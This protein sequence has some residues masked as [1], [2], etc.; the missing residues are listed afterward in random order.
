MAFWWKAQR[1]T[2]TQLIKLNG[3]EVSTVLKKTNSIY[4]AFALSICIG[5]A[6]VACNQ[7]NHDNCKTYQAICDAFEH[8]EKI[9]VI[10]TLKVQQPDAKLHFIEEL[11]RKNIM[12][13]NTFDVV[14]QLLIVIDQEQLEWLA[15]HEQIEAIHLNTFNEVKL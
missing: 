8:S 2:V 1:V 5:I 3:K 6:L 15:N 13:K 4:T 11:K 10:V 9:A 14:P 7:E 12:I